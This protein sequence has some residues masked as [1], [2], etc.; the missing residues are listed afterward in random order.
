MSIPCSTPECDGLQLPTGY[1]SY[2]QGKYIG[3]L[4]RELLLPSMVEEKPVSW[5]YDSVGGEITM[6][7]AAELRL[8][9]LEACKQAALDIAPFRFSDIPNRLDAGIGRRPMTR[10]Q[11]WVLAVGIPVLLTLVALAVRM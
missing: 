2:C 9:V 1:C 10:A 4:T 3:Y 5:F 8:A 7:Q 6:E 11:R